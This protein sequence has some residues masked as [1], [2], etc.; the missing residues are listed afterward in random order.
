[1]RIIRSTR[2]GFIPLNIGNYKSILLDK[3]CINIKDFLLIDKDIDKVIT[4]YKSNIKSSVQEYN[5][6]ASKNNQAV[7][8][9]L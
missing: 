8:K 1:M 2:N 5:Y 4:D 3:V 9:N 7:L 6:I